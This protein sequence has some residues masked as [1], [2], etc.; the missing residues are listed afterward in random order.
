MIIKNNYK[1]KEEIKKEQNNCRRPEIRASNKKWR[2][3][4]GK[5]KFQLQI[6]LEQ[7]TAQT[8]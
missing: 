2:L 5:Y 6:T 3:K 7:K 8:I 1:L 4:K